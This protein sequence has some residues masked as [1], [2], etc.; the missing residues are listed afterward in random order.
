MKTEELQERITTFVST[1]KKSEAKELILALV[2][3]L[4]KFEKLLNAYD[5]QL[6]IAEKAIIEKDKKIST[7]KASLDK[8][9]L[10]I[11]RQLTQIKSLEDAICDNVK[12]L[13]EDEIK[14][15]LARKQRDS[16][17]EKLQNTIAPET[18][19]HLIEENAKLK[20]TLKDLIAVFAASADHNKEIS[21]KLKTILK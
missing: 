2:V 16:Y 6:S 17:S 18:A 4:A 5:T 9:D 7:H 11:Q 19:K 10:T 8:R 20:N 1:E 21:D 13:A 14:I 15:A 12:K 3:E